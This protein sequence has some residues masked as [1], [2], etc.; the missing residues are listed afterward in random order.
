MG[1]YTDDEKKKQRAMYD[2]MRAEL[3]QMVQDL[4]RLSIDLPVESTTRTALLSASNVLETAY[5]ELG[6]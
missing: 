2:S 4:S 3:K 5:R 6:K 1:Y